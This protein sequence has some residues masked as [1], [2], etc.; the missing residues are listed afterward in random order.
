MQKLSKNDRSKAISDDDAKKIAAFI[1][2]P[3]VKLN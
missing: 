3:G 1:R 2:T